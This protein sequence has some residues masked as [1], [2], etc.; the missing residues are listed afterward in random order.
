VST[1]DLNLAQLNIFSH[2]EYRLACSGVGTPDATD[3]AAG[4]DTVEQGVVLM[5]Q[6]MA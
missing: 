1:F 6:V 2:Y 3:A 4:D 5:Y